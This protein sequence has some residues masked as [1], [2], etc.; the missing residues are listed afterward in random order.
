MFALEL[1]MLPGYSVR[2]GV[3]VSIVRSINVRYSWLRW[4][5]LRKALSLIVPVYGLTPL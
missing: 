2:D 1:S 4:W 5:K 3:R